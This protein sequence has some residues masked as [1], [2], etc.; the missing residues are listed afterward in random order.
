MVIGLFIYIIIFLSEKKN[1]KR[2]NPDK[3]YL[4]R[5]RMLLFRKKLTQYW[6]KLVNQASLTK[7]EKETLFKAGKS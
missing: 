1:L 3:K 6:I 2:E 4:N 7:E 5:E